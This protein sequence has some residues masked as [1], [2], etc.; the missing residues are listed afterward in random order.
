M[1]TVSTFLANQCSFGIKPA[2]YS[3]QCFVVSQNG[4]SENEK[5]IKGTCNGKNS[6]SVVAKQSNSYEYDDTNC[7]RSFRPNMQKFIYRCVPFIKITNEY[8]QL[9]KRLITFKKIEINGFEICGGDVPSM[10]KIGI[11][12]N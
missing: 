2:W 12:K 7:A 9:L 10:T 11:I 4:L 3:D 5:N 1:R 8:L 6:C